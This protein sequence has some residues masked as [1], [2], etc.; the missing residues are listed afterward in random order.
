MWMPPQTT[1]PPFRTDRSAA[2]TSAPTGA[3]TSAASSGSGGSLVRAARPDRP[4]GTRE[5]LRRGVS[6][7]RE[8]EDLAPL[9]P[10]HLRDEV[11]GRA[12]APDSHRPRVSRHPQ[13]PVP[14]ESGTE[15]RRRLDVGVAPPGCGKQNRSSATVRLG[16][17]AVDV[18]SGEPGL[19]AEVLVPRGA[20]PAAAT[21]R[22]EPRNSDAVP[23]AE[24]QGFRTARLHDAD[25][26]VPED[27]RELRLRELAVENVEVGPA[28][29][30][31]RDAEEH[32]A[33]TR[34]RVGNVRG[35]ERTAR[36]V[37]K[38]RLHRGLPRTRAGASPRRPHVQYARVTGTSR[39]LPKAH[40]ETFRTM[41]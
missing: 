28:D 39:P 40:S 41:P 1:T 4:E 8:G 26:L 13:G 15:E 23:R 33:G 22:A 30:A 10:R 38:H 24:P 17:A 21:G 35:P 5:F 20:V 37:E 34:D 14:D 29:R 36:N 12:E 2:G 32:L 3:K 7:A 18:V 6:R 25:D 9:E 19:V 31:G 27:E 11:R 16:E